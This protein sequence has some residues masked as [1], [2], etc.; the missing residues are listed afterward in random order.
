MWS[1]HSEASNSSK[2]IIDKHV[3]PDL[4]F[5]SM[6]RP[7]FG[8]ISTIEMKSVHL[9]HMFNKLVNITCRYRFITVFFLENIHW[10]VGSPQEG[11]QLIN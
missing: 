10:L 8:L 5:F 11:Y 3:I 4:I 6:A 9:K 1:V 7:Y 2:C